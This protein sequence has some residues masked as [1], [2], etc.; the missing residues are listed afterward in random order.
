VNLGIRV[1]Q[2]TATSNSFWDMFWEVQ[3]QS[4]FQG[5]LLLGL[6]EGPGAY[7]DKKSL[8]FNHYL[9]GLSWDGS[10]LSSDLLRSVRTF[11]C[12]PFPLVGSSM[13]SHWVLNPWHSV[14]RC[15]LLQQ[16]SF[17][18][19][20]TWNI[21]ASVLLTCKSS[22]GKYSWL[23]GGFQGSGYLLSSRLLLESWSSL[24]P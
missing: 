23:S 3:L 20:V 14:W 2:I 10:Q 5:A 13:S 16:S 6:Y 17:T 11:R 8:V 1:K 18:F 22:Q 15:C 24:H 9:A 12:W 21:N 19:S 7:R 4:L